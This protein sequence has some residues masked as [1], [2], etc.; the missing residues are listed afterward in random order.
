MKPVI[1]IEVVSDVV[2]PW[3]YIGKRRLEK[4]INLSNQ[5]FDFEVEYQPFELNPSMPKEGRNQKEYL[6]SKFGS[7]AQYQNITANT[8]NVA[9]EEG[10]S[11]NFSKQLVS[12]NTRDA[13]R[14]IWF[15][16]EHGKQQ[17]VK[18]AFMKAYFEDGVDLS[19][20]ENLLAVATSAGLDAKQVTD[21][22]NSELGLAD[23]IEAEQLNIQRGVSGVP[24]YIINGKYGISGAQSPTTFAQAFTEIG[25]ELVLESNS[26]D[27]DAKAC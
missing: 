8:T 2:C 18:E 6:I 12:P 26:C 27:V 24:F 7:E 11:F 20:N 10:L 13:H 25:K 21:L 4:A 23:V 1:K 14:I 17:E 3:C 22:L 19:K 16:K 15:A 9:A 5:D